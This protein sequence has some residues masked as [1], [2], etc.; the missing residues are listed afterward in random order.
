MTAPRAARRQITVWGTSDAGGSSIEDYA[1]K[2]WSGLM[3][4]FYRGRCAPPAAC[5]AAPARGRAV[6]AVALWEVVSQRRPALPTA[7]QAAAVQT[8]GASRL[9]ACCMLWLLLWHALPGST[10]WASRLLAL[11]LCSTERA[12]APP[13]GKRA[14]SSARTR[15]TH[16]HVQCMR[17]PFNCVPTCALTQKHT[18][19]RCRWPCHARCPAHVC[20]V[21][22]VHGLPCVGAISKGPRGGRACRRY[23][24][25]AARWTLFVARLEANLRAGAAYDAEAWRRECLEFTLAWARGRE[26][27]PTEAAGDAVAVSVRLFAKYEKAAALGGPPL[28]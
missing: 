18:A 12:C 15:A 16:M 27:F 8:L 4:S 10:S 11:Q 9:L 20:S 26:R 7:V 2:Q 24:V 21:S 5:R 3:G 14:R 19:P 13:P 25:R 23:C 17:M 1:N 28:L 6:Q 22:L